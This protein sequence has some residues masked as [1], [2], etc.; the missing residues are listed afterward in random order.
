MPRRSF[1]AIAVGIAVL[2]FT[3]WRQNDLL[4]ILAPMLKTPPVPLWPAAA[5]NVLFVVVA[6]SPG[7]CAGWISGQR[8]ILIGMLTGLIGS[9]GYSVLS[10]LLHIPWDALNASSLIVWFAGWGLGLTLT[11]AAGGATGE[12]LRSNKPESGP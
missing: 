5:V 9:L 1:I 12:L 4:L 7:F 2:W 11:C 6:L 10:A 3:Q 8:G